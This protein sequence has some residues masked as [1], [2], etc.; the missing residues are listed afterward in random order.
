MPND[1]NA[2]RY[3][4]QALTHH[5][6]LLAREVH[7]VSKKNGD[8]ITRAEALAKLLWDKALG[9]ES[10]ERNDMGAVVTVTHRP[11][12]WAIQL[13]YDRLEGRVP[14]APEEDND[15]PRALENLRRVARERANAIAS[16]TTL[17]KDLAE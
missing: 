1:S 14:N 12:S 6:R 17:P 2:N 3:S 16:Q 8:P 13:L 5:L 10:Q 4:K 15:R 7:D 9:Y 11:E